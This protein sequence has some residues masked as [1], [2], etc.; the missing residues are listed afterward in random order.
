MRFLCLLAVTFPMIL[1][2]PSYAAE[3]TRP[4]DSELRP[5][6]DKAI[7]YLQAHQDEDGCFSKGRAGV[8][9]T[10]LVAAALIRNGHGPEHPVVARAL[11]FL[12]GKIQKDG[13]VYEQILANYMT[14]VALLTFKEANTDGRYDKVIK[15]ATAFLKTLQYDESKEFDP[16]KPEYGGVGYDGKSRP[17]LSNMHLFVEAMRAA[18]VPESD[19]AL[20]RA[21]IF[22]SRCQNL[23]G[24]HNDQPFAKLATEDD[25]GGFIYTPV[26][27]KGGQSAAGPNDNGGLRSAGVMTYAG[28]KSF[29]Y[30]GVDRKDPRVVAAIDWIRRHYTVDENPGQGKSGL[31]YYYHVFAKAMYALDAGDAFV[32]SKGVTHFWRVD[33]FKALKTQQQADGSWVNDQD[34]FMEGDKNL[35]TAFA[36]LSLSYCRPTTK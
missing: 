34:K 12:E 5:V 10:A 22:I 33:L 9:V 13:G 21:V 36:L 31:Y 17:D 2:T 25:K 11:K 3:P 26:T 28:L 14:S 19:P 18:G 6:I 23:P 7:V 1:G 27:G 20:K 15:N 29:L 24:E 35:C 16:T 32:D 4:A 8:G 30:A